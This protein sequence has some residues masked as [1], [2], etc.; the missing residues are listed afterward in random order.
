MNILS[1]ISITTSRSIKDLIPLCL[2]DRK[3][4]ARSNVTEVIDYQHSVLEVGLPLFSSKVVAGFP[5]PAED[6]VE[7]RL[8]PNSYLIENEIAT[9]CLR[10]MGDSMI[11]AGI[12]DKDVLIVDRSRHAQIGDIVLAVLD[13]EFT[14]KTLG[15]SKQ[16]PRLIPA[17]PNYPIIEIKDGQQ[18]EI[19]GVVTGSMR[20]FK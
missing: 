16:G 19:W 15:H 4:L 17:N 18:F 11:G 2:G 12:F 9:F 7:Q 20:K 13:G 6:H 8:Q 5:S 14:V 1:N 3:Q 10:V